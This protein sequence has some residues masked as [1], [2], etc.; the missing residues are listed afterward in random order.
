VRRWK[1][2]E[3]FCELTPLPDLP[4][5]KTGSAAVF[6]IDAHPVSDDFATGYIDDIAAG[7]HQTL[8]RDKYKATW[9]FADTGKRSGDAQCQRVKL[10]ILPIGVGVCGWY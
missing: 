9:T 10:V 5:F 7:R 4:L 1:I 2:D 3:N 6:G 8:R